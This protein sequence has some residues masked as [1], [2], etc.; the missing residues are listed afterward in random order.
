MIGK[1]LVP[2]RLRNLSPAQRRL[3]ELIQSINYGRIENI[4][5]RGGE[6]VLDPPPRVVREIKFSGTNDPRPERG[7]ADFA[8]KEQHRELFRV[9]DQL[10]DGVLAVLTVKAGLPFLA[11][12]AG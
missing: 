3:V 4:L 5:V 2:S 9:L 10:G 6:P 12:L 7:L 1:P 11:E 8:L